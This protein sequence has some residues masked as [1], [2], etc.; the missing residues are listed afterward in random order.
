MIK[1]LFSSL[2]FALILSIRF[3]I[4]ILKSIGIGLDI[5]ITNNN[6]ILTKH[7]ERN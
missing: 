3:L 1:F 5:K 2:K 4:I 6:Y 7:R